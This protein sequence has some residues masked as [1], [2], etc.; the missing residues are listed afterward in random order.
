MKVHGRN[1]IYRYVPNFM[2]NRQLPASEQIVVNLKSVAA[3]EHDAYQHACLNATREYAPDK[4]QE[5]NE[6]R[7]GKLVQEKFVGVEGLE[8]EGLEGKPLDYATFYREAPQVI[9][10][11]VLRVIMSTEL[12]TLGQQKN[13]VP[14][15]GSPSPTPA[16]G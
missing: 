16:A 2:N 1:H 4:A 10:N 15:S 3:D 9:V 11:E 13:F 6:A 14:E 7:F 8:I 5:L 12:L